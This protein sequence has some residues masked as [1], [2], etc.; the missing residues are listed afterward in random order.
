LVSVPGSKITALRTLPILDIRGAPIGCLRREN[1]HAAA[2]ERDPKEAT[3]DVRVNGIPI[4]RIGMGDTITM[5]QRGVRAGLPMQ[6]CTVN[7][8]FLVNARLDDEVRA[9]LQESDVNVADGAPVVWLSRF[10]G[11]DVPE[12][13]AG[14]DL[15]PALLGVAAR[16][17]VPVF[18]LGG[19]DGVAAACAD[20][21]RIRWPRIPAV[22]WFEPPRQSLDEMDSDDI[23]RRINASG[24]RLLFVALGHPK[25]DKWIRRHRGSLGP[26][27]A[28]GV[29]CSFDV[30]VGRTRRAPIWM[31]HSG[32][33]WLYRVA[34]EPRRLFRRYARDAAW[35]PVFALAAAMQRRANS[36][37]AA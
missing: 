23:V 9:V 21:I 25:Q 19:E 10:V 20:A 33:E 27:V 8:D 29:G 11:K 16:L 7:L 22:E 1:V 14:A 24:A 12:R 3:P 15:F 4:R 36:S 31:Q 5:V 18:L 26:V 35:L 17:G 2:L 13:V 32:L 30:F 37:A 6:I 34:S 28:M